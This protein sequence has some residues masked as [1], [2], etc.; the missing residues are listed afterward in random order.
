MAEEV[1]IEANGYKY[2][3]E[4]S[5]CM[6]ENT[7]TWV[8]VAKMGGG[9]VGRRYAGEHWAVLLESR[10]EIVMQGLYN[11]GPDF[12]SHETTAVAL[13]NEIKDDALED[14]TRLHHQVRTRAYGFKCTT[15]RWCGATFLDGSPTG[16]CPGDQV[17]HGDP[18]KQNHSC[19]TFKTRGICKHV[20]H[21]CICDVCIGKVAPFVP[22][23][24]VSPGGIEITSP[25]DESPV[26]NFKKAFEKFKFDVSTGVH[27]SAETHG[28]ILYVCMNCGKKT[29]YPNSDPTECYENT[30]L[31]DGLGT[32]N[33]VPKGLKTT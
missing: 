20:L 19:E 28:A 10:G 24:T 23:G 21:R 25:A 18:I 15:C 17:L 5:E 22:V 3:S 26:V 9:T 2:D 7:Y 27:A 4:Y 6:N 8:H 16:P 32:H 11:P 1:I 30:H 31:G 13:W 33:F 14:K 29:H 12:Y